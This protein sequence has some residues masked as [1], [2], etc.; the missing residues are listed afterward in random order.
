LNVTVPLPGWKVPRLVQLPL[1]KILLLLA[2]SVPALIVRLVALVVPVSV[3]PLF[4]VKIVYV[5]AGILLLAVKVQFPAAALGIEIAPVE[6][7]IRPELERV[8]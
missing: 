7:V 1:T 2:L 5:A 3:P 8:V 4:K 6:T